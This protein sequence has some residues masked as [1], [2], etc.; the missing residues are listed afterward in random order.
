MTNGTGP[1][2]GQKV[3]QDEKHVKKVVIAREPKRSKEQAGQT[4]RK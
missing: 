4:E 3:G 2:E 1:K